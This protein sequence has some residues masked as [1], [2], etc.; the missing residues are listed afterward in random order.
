MSDSTLKF[1]HPY[2][3]SELHRYEKNISEETGS[4]HKGDNE[5]NLK[6]PNNN[7]MYFI[8]PFQRKRNFTA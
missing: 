6:L 3:I 2:T 5:T 4:L 8:Y 1:F 7:I